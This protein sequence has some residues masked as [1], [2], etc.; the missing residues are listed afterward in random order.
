M[1]STG[2]VELV[3]AART[4]CLGRL[5]HAVQAADDGQRQ[6]DLAVLGL[7][8]VAA[9]QVGDRPDEA[10]Q[11]LVRTH[12]DP[13]PSVLWLRGIFRHEEPR[14]QAVHGRLDGMCGQ[15]GDAVDPIGD[16]HEPAERLTVTALFGQ[17][18]PWY[19]RP[20]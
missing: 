10:G 17:R 3:P 16:R 19:A 18:H 7:L 8:V 4:A 1:F 13:F 9:E 6:D 2:R 20:S 14:C 15:C 11:F 12:G 5:Q